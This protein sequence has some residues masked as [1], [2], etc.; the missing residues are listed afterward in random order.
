[1]LIR[2]LNKPPAQGAVALVLLV[3]FASFLFLR[4]SD[5]RFIARAE[6]P[7]QIHFGSLDKSSSSFWSGSA[8]QKHPVVSL[9]EEAAKKYEHLISSQSKTLDQA[10]AKYK[11]KFNRPPPK[12]FDLWFQAAKKDELVIVDDYDTITKSTEPYWHVPPAIL[13]RNVARANTNK[14]WIKDLTIT[15]GRPGSTWP[16]EVP[17]YLF[18]DLPIQLEPYT[19]ALSHIEK[20]HVLTNK[21]DYVDLPRVMLPYGTPAWTASPQD[22]KFKWESDLLVGKEPGNVFH[23]IDLQDQFTWDILKFACPPG[24]PIWAADQT[25]FEPKVP[26]FL[27]NV[28]QSKEICLHPHY[29]F[30]HG[31]WSPNDH[32]LTMEPILVL[33][34]AKTSLNSD[35]L[36][37]SLYYGFYHTEQNTTSWRDK[38]NDL[39]WAGSTTGVHLFEPLD[40][41]S[42]P[43]QRHRFVEFVNDMVEDDSSDGSGHVSRYSTPITLLEQAVDPRTNRPRGPWRPRET[44]MSEQT[45]AGLYNVRFTAD[46]QCLDEATCARQKAHFNISGWWEHGAEHMNHRFLFDIDGNG[47]SGRFYKLLASNATVF[48]VTLFQEWHDDILIPWYHYVPVSVGME[49]LPELMRFFAQ[50]EEGSNL[51]EKI[52]ANAIEFEAM[53]LGRKTSGAGWARMLLELNRLLGDG[54]DEGKLD[55][56]H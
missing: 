51:A 52:A 25:P 7:T 45:Q 14:E 44:T 8:P 26:R 43:S 54:R 37:P 39:Y 12:G 21:F 17:W 2:A 13:R 28:A 33:S 53:A 19:S 1:M 46:P 18:E 32:K 6:P 23:W 9:Y 41:H 42:V 5:T 36:I 16:N 29:R 40:W 11:Q 4:R 47:F 27:T 22:K 56:F 24:S 30:Q 15:K 49:E 48:K 55:I 20:L 10:V 50:T 35:I 3:V 34:G 31:I 38:I